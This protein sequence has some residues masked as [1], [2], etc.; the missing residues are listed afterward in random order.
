MVEVPI[1]VILNGLTI[2]AIYGLMAIGLSLI[3]S[4]VGI[5]NS[6]HGGFYLLG[7]YLGYFFQ[8]LGLSV[9]L[10]MILAIILVGAIGIVVYRLTIHPILNLHANVLILTFLLAI[11]FEQIIR[12]TFG[13][14]YKNLQPLV[15]GVFEG[16]GIVMSNQRITASILS[17]ILV[18]LLSLF[19]KRSRLGKAIRMTTQD[20]E[21]A[22]LLGIDV[23]LIY[24]LTFGLGTALTGAS[25]VLAAPLFT[26]YP[27]MGW[28]PFILSFFITISGGLGSVAGALVMGVI[29]G[30]TDAFVSYYIAPTWGLIA[31]FLVTLIIIIVKPQGL[32]GR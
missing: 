18:A 5:A 21:A 1:Q 2:G 14:D 25:A 15:T 11:L 6:A 13:P 16:A 12:I 8:I 20:S 29:F 30:L 19:V 28:L 31:A 32:L 10:A 7:A 3:F 27:A 4:V 26:L 24:V 23:S 9:P 22:Q 17:V